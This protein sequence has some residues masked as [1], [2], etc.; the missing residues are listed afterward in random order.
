MEIV[1]RNEKN[2]LCIDH[3]YGHVAFVVLTD[4][5]KK[6]D[7]GLE[8]EQWKQLKNFVDDSIYKYEREMEALKQPSE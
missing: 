6:I 7:F 4:D 8:I 5:D 1:L 3:S 2:E